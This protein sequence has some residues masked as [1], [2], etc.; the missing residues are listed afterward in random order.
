MVPR[1]DSYYSAEDPWVLRGGSWDDTIDIGH[2]QLLS[3]YR[4]HVSI[5]G[6]FAGILPVEELGSA[7]D[8]I[9][10]RCVVAREG[11]P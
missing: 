6:R 11:L 3:S 1:K 2:R 7:A 4:G 8:N 5:I 9:G 10:F